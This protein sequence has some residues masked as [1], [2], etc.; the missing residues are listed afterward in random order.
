MFMIDW[1]FDKMGYTKKVYWAEILSTLNETKP[2]KKIV[3]HKPTVKKT[4]TR[5]ARKKL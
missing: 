1:L 3:K 4:T 5:P 2:A